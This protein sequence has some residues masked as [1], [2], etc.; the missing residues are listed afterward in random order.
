MKQVVVTGIG[1]RTPLGSDLDT[2]FDA[3][4]AQRSGVRAQPE[5]SKVEDL[6]SLV[7]ASVDEFDGKEIPR[8]YRRTMGRVAMFAAAA[9][10]DAVDQAGL[11]PTALQTGRAGVAVGSTL[12]SHRADSEFW[13]HFHTTGSA[14]GV[15]GTH[16]FKIMAHTCATHVALFLGTQ[17]E[18]VATNAACASAT[19]A[20]GNALDRIRAGR[21]DVMIAG[22]ADELHVA[23]AITFDAMGGGS[24]AYNESPTSTPR[25]FDKDRDGIVVGEGAGILVLEEEQHA[26]ARGAH[27]LGRVLGYGGTSD[28]QNM[29]SPAPAGMK[30]AIELALMDGGLG[31]EEIGYVNA[32]ATGTPIGDAAEAEALFQL[33][34]DRVPVSSS[35]G[36][37][38]HMMGACGAVEAAISLEAMRRG[39]VPPTLN[40]ETPDVAPLHLPAQ[41][42]E[43]PVRAALSTNFAFGGVNAAVLLGPGD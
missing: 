9:A 27:I 7:A 39:C 35:K 8:K 2:V 14:R 32:H 23:A 37:L 3:L 33:F 12:G 6:Q 34:G 22:G 26:R 17:G 15:K 41:A 18:A 38:G 10:K 1:L 5:W 30:Q 29:A 19:Q 13:E 43:Q 42:L 16:F 25:P 31:V 36:H 21:A 20:L 28:A 40:L 4:I 24:R 11:S